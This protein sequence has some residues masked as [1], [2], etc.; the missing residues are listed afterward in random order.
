MSTGDRVPCAGLLSV[1]DTVIE[2]C[3]SAPKKALDHALADRLASLIARHPGFRDRMA[4]VRRASR[5]IGA[6]DQLACL[7]ISLAG[8]DR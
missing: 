1:V 3:N 8:S 6:P 7:S 5:V 2:A 4:R